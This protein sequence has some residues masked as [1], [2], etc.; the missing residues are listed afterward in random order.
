MSCIDK[1]AVFHSNMV[2]KEA[3]GLAVTKRLLLL[4]IYIENRTQKPRREVGLNLD[5]SCHFGGVRFLA[6]HTL[7]IRFCCSI[8]LLNTCINCT[9]VKLKNEIQAETPEIY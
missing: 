1:L 7:Y 5:S 4:A 8:R 9:V 2:L 6:N 3:W